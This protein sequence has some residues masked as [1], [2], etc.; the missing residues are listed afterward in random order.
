MVGGLGDGG[1]E[2]DLIARSPERRV[3]RHYFRYF[4]NHP[5]VSGHA[6][7]DAARFAG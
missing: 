3:A 4:L 6:S 5:I 2:R 7:S 1:G